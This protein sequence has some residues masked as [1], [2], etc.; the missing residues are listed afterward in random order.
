MHFPMIVRPQR[1]GPLIDP[2]HPCRSRPERRATV[3]IMNGVAAVDF[4]FARQMLQRG[5]AVLFILGFLSTLNQFRPLAGERG[6]LPA[7]DLLLR[8]RE[9]E[10]ER[11]Q[12]MLRPT[13]F[14]WAGYT[15]LRLALV[16]WAGMTVAFLLVAGVPQLGPPWV[17]MLSLIHI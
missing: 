17:P 4:E 6:L 2:S 15:D 7:P 14:R 12:K 13:L 1:Y 9:I 10:H 3:E 11:G 16:C 5:I 8:A